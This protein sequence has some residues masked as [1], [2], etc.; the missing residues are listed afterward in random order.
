MPRRRG[1]LGP[2]DLCAR[3]GLYEGRLLRG[4]TEMHVDPFPGG[5]EGPVEHPHRAALIRGEG[6]EWLVLF[7]VYVFVAKYVLLNTVVGAL[8]ELVNL[9]GRQNVDRVDREQC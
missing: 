9:V 7:L 3:C 6:A 5:H 4:L 2:A 1:T 8:A